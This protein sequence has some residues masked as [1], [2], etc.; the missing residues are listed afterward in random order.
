MRQPV[1][2][3]AYKILYKFCKNWISVQN[4]VHQLTLS[5]RCTVKSTAAVISKMLSQADGRPP[6]INGDIAIQWE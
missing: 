2:Q 6:C 1:K 5:L 3:I 4:I